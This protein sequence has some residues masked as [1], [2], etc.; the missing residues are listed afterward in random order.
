MKK[1]SRSA[2]SR[3]RTPPPRRAFADVSHETLHLG[4][5]RF[6][7]DLVRVEIEVVVVL[8]HEHRRRLQRR[9][10]VV[11]HERDVV[12]DRRRRRRQPLAAALAF[13]SSPHPTDPLPPSRQEPPLVLLVQRGQ[14]LERHP[15]LL[16]ARASSQPSMTRLR[17][18]PQV[19]ESLRL[20]IRTRRHHRVVPR[21]EQRQLQ[22]RH[23]PGLVHGLHE[24]HAIAEDAAL[25]DSQ[26]L[27]VRSRV[28]RRRLLK[29]SSHEDVVLK[30]VRVPRRIRVERVQDVERL[31][32]RG[33]FPALRR[34]AHVLPLI[35]GLEE[36]VR[37]RGAKRRAAADD[38]RQ[39][40]A[41]SRADVALHAER[42]AVAPGRVHVHGGS[43]GRGRRRGGE[44]GGG[45][46]GGERR[47]R[48]PPRGPRGSD[49]ETPALANAAERASARDRVH[50]GQAPRA[51][52]PRA[53][54]RAREHAT[55]AVRVV[56][57]RRGRLR[58]ARA[59]GVTTSRGRG[60]SCDSSAV[61]F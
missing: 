42:H 18:R 40:R 43:G 56:V 7:R 20:Q 46:G 59:G 48:R 3:P 11:V 15:G 1:K 60:D 6:L 57:G 27:R 25:H 61:P 28:S 2:S 16:P 31:A 53:R 23:P 32:V 33:R 54:S 17:R 55:A 51:R 5:Q 22:V 8:H 52:G 14:V 12:A 36:D 47:D 21:V 37:P 45:G 4:A 39:K 38:V 10:A 30:R 49:D 9:D 44:G 41:L 50:R 13:L 24:D 26:R 19:H 58:G 34:G 35:H 29:K